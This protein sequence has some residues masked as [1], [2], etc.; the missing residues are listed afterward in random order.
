M[1]MGKDLRREHSMRLMG[2]FIRFRFM[3]INGGT[4]CNQP[5]RHEAMLE[6]YEYYHYCSVSSF[7]AGSC[8]TKE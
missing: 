5:D 3:N 4:C 2:C 8:I 6:Q 7:V 1:D